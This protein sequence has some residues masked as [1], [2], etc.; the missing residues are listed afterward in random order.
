MTD[1]VKLGARLPAGDWNGL[2]ALGPQ[3]DAHADGTFVVVAILGCDQLVN[4]VRTDLRE[5]RMDIR[6]IEVLAGDDATEARATLLRLYEERT[7][8]EPLP[9]PFDG[10]LEDP[11]DGDDPR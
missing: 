5:A 1:I 11:G 3:I 8:R 7:G 10:S 6:R 9:N 4:K 2:N